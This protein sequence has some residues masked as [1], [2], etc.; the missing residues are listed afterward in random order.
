MKVFPPDFI[1]ALSGKLSSDSDTSVRYDNKTGRMFSYKR[2]K[3][4]A[5]LSDA[6]RKGIDLLARRRTYAKSI[7]NNPDLWADYEKGYDKQNT[8]ATPVGYLV[9]LIAI[10]KIT[11]PPNF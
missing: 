9:H 6:Q 1:A 4:P 3:E 2:K 8:Y 5:P 10:G 7:V 11:L